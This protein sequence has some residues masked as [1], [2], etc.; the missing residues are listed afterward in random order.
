MAK[1]KETKRPVTSTV[2]S[3]YRR[4]LHNFRFPPLKWGTNHPNPLGFR[5]HSDSARKE[6][7]QRDTPF[8]PPSPSNDHGSCIVNEGLPVAVSSS[9][10]ASSD[11]GIVG[12]K[13]NISD[14]RGRNVLRFRTKKCGEGK[15]DRDSD[16]VAA[17]TGG[18]SL[19]SVEDADENPKIR[20]LKPRKVE[21]KKSVGNV[22]E[23]PLGFREPYDSA[24]TESRQRDTPSRL[25]SPSKDHGRRM[26]NEGRPVAVSSSFHASSDHG[27]VGS[28]KN[29]SDERGRN[30]L[31]F[32]TKK[33]G[34]GK[35][36]RD[37]DAVAA[38]T[39][40]R[41]LNSVEDAEENPKIRNLKPRKVEFKKSVGN[42]DE[43]PLGSR[44]HYDS[45]RTES[46]QRH[47]P[48]RLVSP[49]KDHGSRMVNEGHP[50]AVS[51]SFHSSSDHGIVGSK[52]NISEEGGR[53][54]LRFRTKKYGDDK[55]DSDNDAVAA[56]T[57]GRNLNSV[58]DAEENPKIRDLRPRKVGFKT[59][60]G[61]VKADGGVSRIGGAVQ[62]VDQGKSS[63]TE[64][65]RSRTKP[66]ENTNT[67]TK[68]SV[69]L[70]KE[71]IEADFIAMTGSNP[72]R[73]PRKRTKRLQRRL[74][75]SFPG[76]RLDTI[77]PSS[78]EVSDKPKN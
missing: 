73:R 41:N 30:V 56:R 65:T 62:R 75:S 52:K 64:S 9:F 25:V 55:N 50:V 31:R 39:G 42:V 49:S 29:I 60:V 70:K 13:K 16:V 8:R 53:N 2:S 66:K 4:P 33:Y 44:K 58:E 67:N 38:R 69:A 68:F 71:E 48:S 3:K 18:R 40:G 1:E 76:L 63:Q 32:R 37:S 36:D 51:S 7:P 47:T 43:N 74:D 21:F 11:H 59:S 46:H 35:N 34:E 77:T 54:V 6:S 19:N 20:N 24:R 28:K 26:V 17:R 27:I 22:D 78:Y 10:Q 14:E 61:N 15:N 23:N 72:S 57:S 12:S 45:A 5:K